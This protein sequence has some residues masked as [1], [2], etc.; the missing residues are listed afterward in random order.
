MNILVKSN[1]EYL[2][3]EIKEFFQR[4]KAN[5][6]FTDSAECAIDLLNKHKINMVIFDFNSLLDT[7]LLKYIEN[8]YKNVKVILSADKYMRNAITVFQNNNFI[9]LDNP[10]KLTELK[11]LI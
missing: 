6:Y 10:L 8:Y 5:T 3:N 11:N 9:L 7:V 4:E 2:E 1:K